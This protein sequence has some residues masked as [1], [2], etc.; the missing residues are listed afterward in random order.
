M[1]F[2]ANIQISEGIFWEFSFQWLNNSFFWYVFDPAA[3]LFL[4]VAT[5]PD[6]ANVMVDMDYF[7]RNGKPRR[8]AATTRQA[9]P[10]PSSGTK[11]V[12][13]SAQR[14]E[15]EEG[16]KGRRSIFGRG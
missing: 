4:H 13:I 15:E 14:D 11:T 3:G 12:N 5:D 1:F 8:V 2:K 16:N 6:I 10:P 9:P 7:A